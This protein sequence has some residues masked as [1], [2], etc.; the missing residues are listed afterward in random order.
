MTEGGLGEPQ[1][2]AARPMDR[3]CRNGSNSA[4]VLIVPCSAWTP[5]VPTPMSSAGFAS[6]STGSSAQELLA[7]PLPLA[8]CSRLPTIDGMECPTSHQQGCREDPQD[9]YPL[10]TLGS[11]G[12]S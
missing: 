4:T 1:E 3:R 5:S 9:A 6:S 8:S 12:D 11:Y 7:N 10:T 2:L